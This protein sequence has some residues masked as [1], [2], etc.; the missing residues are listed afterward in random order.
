MQLKKEASVLR[1][2]STL[3]NMIIFF[4]KITLIIFKKPESIP[5]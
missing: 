2:N 3:Q 5:P 1:C 4:A